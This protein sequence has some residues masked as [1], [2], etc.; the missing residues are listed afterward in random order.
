VVSDRP[1]PVGRWVHVAV[2]YHPETRMARLWLDGQ[3]VGEEELVQLPRGSFIV[4][5]GVD[6][7]RPDD[8]LAGWLDDLRLSESL[9]W[10]EPFEPPVCPRA[11]GDTAVLWRFEVEADEEETRDRSEGEWALK[12]VTLHGAERVATACEARTPPPANC[13]ALLPSADTVCEDTPLTCRVRVQLGG[14]SCSD[15]CGARGLVCQGAA[16]VDAT[17]GPGDPLGGGCAEGAAEAQCTCA[18]P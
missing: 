18:R 6:E 14:A 12:R 8:L 10:T 3:P 15:W 11:D 2:T 5:V 7:P 4:K 1:V 16:T 17:C 9:R 13:R